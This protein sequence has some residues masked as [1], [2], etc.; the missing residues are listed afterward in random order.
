[1]CRTRQNQRPWGGRGC[2]RAQHACCLGLGQAPLDPPLPRSGR[3]WGR[4]LRKPGSE[5]WMGYG[6]V[7]SLYDP[8]QV[9][10]PSGWLLLGLGSD[11][12]QVGGWRLGKGLREKREGALCSGPTHH[13]AGEAAAGPDLEHEH[14]PTQ[15]GH[16]VKVPVADVGA[17]LVRPL[18]G[19]GLGWGTWLWGPLRLPAWRW[20]LRRPGR[21]V[22]WPAWPPRSH[23]GKRPGGLWLTIRGACRGAGGEVRG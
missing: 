23:S 4:R 3:V 5:P 16:R 20:W 10:C 22:V 12:P 8:R 13:G 2:E 7:G 21:A 11:G 6:H 17:I 19:S 9:P 1:M 15:H 18:C 14:L